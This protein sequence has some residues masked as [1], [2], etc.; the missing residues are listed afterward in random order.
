MLVTCRGTVADTWFISIDFANSSHLGENDSINLALMSRR[1]T[2]QDDCF[3]SG[4][5]SPPGRLLRRTERSS[6]RLTPE[7]RQ[8]FS[9]QPRHNFARWMSLAE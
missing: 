1:H 5:I 7:C 3:P 4:R 9:M 8:V 2:G 6:R